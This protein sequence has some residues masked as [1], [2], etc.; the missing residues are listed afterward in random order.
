MKV[1]VLG[2][3]Q[4]LRGL[5]IQT[6]CDSNCETSICNKKLIN[7]CIMRD[8][9]FVYNKYTKDNNEDQK[10]RILCQQDTVVTESE[11]PKIFL[12]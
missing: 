7:F 10:R 1:Q 12:F 9:I 3:R 2:I 11:N 6:R 8:N 5:N 4:V